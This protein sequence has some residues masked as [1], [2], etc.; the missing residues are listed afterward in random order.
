[1]FP[2]LWLL[3]LYLVEI[4]ITLLLGNSL[5]LGK[6][7]YVPANDHEH[8]VLK[9]SDSVTTQ[10]GWPVSGNY[11][12]VHWTNVSTNE[13]KSFINNKILNTLMCTSGGTYEHLH[14]SNEEPD[15]NKSIKII[16][17]LSKCIGKQTVIEFSGAI[18]NSYLPEGPGKVHIHSKYFSKTTS[19]KIC[20]KTLPNVTAIVGR[21][22][23]GIPSGM[24]KVYYSDGSI[25]IGYLHNG[26][27]Y[28]PVKVLSST[29]QPDLKP[30]YFGYFVAGRPHGPASVSY[31]HLT[32]PT[33]RE[34]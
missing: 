10:Y 6:S 12:N 17:Q 31:T 14:G 29:S 9:H 3:M 18:S 16:E 21:F 7:S 15:A 8:K 30:I 1:M 23:R 2:S 32:L 13:L 4:K 26:S 25:Y 19:N 20:F 5:A 28:G 34:V 27:F 22:S 11:S 24:S 33:N